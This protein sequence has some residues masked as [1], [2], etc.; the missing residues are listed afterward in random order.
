VS[1]ITVIAAKCSST[2][3]PA[4]FKSVLIHGLMT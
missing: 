3:L 4:G 1:T 2:H